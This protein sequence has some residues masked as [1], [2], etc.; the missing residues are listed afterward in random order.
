MVIDKSRG[1][2]RAV[3]LLLHIEPEAK[4]RRPV[5]FLHLWP[6]ANSSTLMP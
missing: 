3:E 5:N 4:P 2:L 6:G 1:W